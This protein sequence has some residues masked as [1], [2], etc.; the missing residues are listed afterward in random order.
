MQQRHTSI[1]LHVVRGAPCE[2]MRSPCVTPIAILLRAPWAPGSASILMSAFNL[3]VQVNPCELRR[4]AARGDAR[5][6]RRRDLQRRMQQIEACYA[7]VGA[8]GVKPVTAL[9]GPLHHLCHLEGAGRGCAVRARVVPRPNSRTSMP[10]SVDRVE[11]L[12][13]M[14]RGSSTRALTAS[15]HGAPW[16]GG[17]PCSAASEDAKWEG[18]GVAQS[19]HPCDQTGQ[20]AQAPP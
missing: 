13:M 15:R 18:A 19:H 10:A 1:P 16:P 12:R 3:G 17:G 11:R 2:S 14:Q 7:S 9:R 5:P 8:G 6:A 20:T 4:T